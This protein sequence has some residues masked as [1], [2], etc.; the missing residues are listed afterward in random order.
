FQWALENLIKNAL[1]A[2]DPHQKG[3]RLT[4]RSRREEKELVIDVE[5]TGKGIEKKQFKEVFK[6]GFSTKKRG[7]GLGLSLT[8]RII[9]EYNNV[10][11]YVLKS[12]L[13]RGTT[14][15]IILPIS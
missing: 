11:V 5:D 12:T 13:G 9:E 2:I 6:P 10:K 8:K 14:F 3:S 1:D 4:I 15:R 7:W